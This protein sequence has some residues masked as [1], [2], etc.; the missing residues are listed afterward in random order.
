MDVTQARSSPSFCSYPVSL[1]FLIAVAT[2]S[3]AV[4]GDQNQ[5]ES[6]RKSNVG[7]PLHADKGEG[8]IKA[9]ST[10]NHPP[11][12]YHSPEIIY[13]I[14]P[15]DFDWKEYA[16]V[17]AAIETLDANSENSWPIIVEH[18]TDTDYCFT[19]QFCDSAVNYSRGDVCIRIAQTWINGGYSAF[20]PGGDGQH[21]RLPAEGPKALQ[22]WCRKRRDKT[23]V[24]IEIDAAEW[25]IS[26]IR[27]ERRPP[28]ELLDASISG[29]RARITKLRQTNKPVHRHFFEPDAVACYSQGEAERIRKLIGVK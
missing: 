7:V 2:G 15:T 18:M 24:E 25:A 6:G 5:T 4:A 11:K 21:F 3:W 22:E 23:F 20:M 27:D 29:I 28:V 1:M 17:L 9:L 10:T 8:L 13:P 14:F 26:T 19:V 16:R 12:L